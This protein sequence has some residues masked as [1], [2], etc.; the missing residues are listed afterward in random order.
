LLH[1]L[2]DKLHT[3]IVTSIQFPFS[4]TFCLTS[5]THLH[6]LPYNFPLA[7]PSINP[8]IHTCSYF[9][10]ISLYFHL[11]SG[12]LHTLI[13]TSLQYPFSS[14]HLQFL[15]HILP[16]ASTS[17][18]PVTH[19]YISFHTISVLLHLLSDQVHILIFISI[20]FPFSST[21]CHTSYTHLQ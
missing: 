8:V 1:L 3:L 2:S 19:T 21:F 16:F 7:P 14:T 9:H 12:R 10:T 4:S 20:Q 15:P 18:R 11:L 17:V 13:V 6:S 5:Y